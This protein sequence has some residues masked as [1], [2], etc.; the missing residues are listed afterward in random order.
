MSDEL[1]SKNLRFSF[2]L[3]ALLI[4]LGVGSCQRHERYMASINFCETAVTGHSALVWAPCEK[5]R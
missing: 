2:V 3:V 1:F 4:L 5:Q